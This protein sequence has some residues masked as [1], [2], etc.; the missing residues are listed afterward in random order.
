MDSYE[1][2]KRHMNAKVRGIRTSSAR[3]YLEQCLALEPGQKLFYPCVDKQDQERMRVIFSTE[4]KRLEVEE[5][6]A[7]TIIRITK[8]EFNGELGIMLIKYADTGAVVIINPDGSTAHK[9]IISTPREEI[10]ER[11]VEMIGEAKLS[12]E[13]IENNLRGYFPTEMFPSTIELQNA[14]RWARKMLLDNPGYFV[15]KYED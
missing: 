3:S 12:P 6:D 9:M 2:D 1:V 10:A 5:P 15:P 13:D 11:I 8:S 4:R 14:L 7:G